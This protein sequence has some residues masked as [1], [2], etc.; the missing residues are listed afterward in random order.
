MTN[1]EAQHILNKLIGLPLWSI[2]RAADLEWFAFGTE[3]REIPLRNG[4][5]KIVGDYALHIQ[6][7]W[8]FRHKHKIL[9]AHHDR[10]YPAGDD[11]YKD[12]LEFDWDKPGANQLDQR[13]E[14]L[15]Q[16][17]EESHLVEQQVKVEET[18][19][20]S[21]ELND[22]YF[23]E[24]FPDNSIVTEYWRF[25]KPYGKQKHF[26]FTNEGVKRE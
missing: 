24:A 17:Y 10:F 14:Q 3:R 13:A 16:A 5:S 12:L 19:D 1:Q 20:L 6:C 11:P 7:A 4:N 18:G 8:R 26:V 9:F 25:F 21:I 2:G 23:L 22:G 15:M